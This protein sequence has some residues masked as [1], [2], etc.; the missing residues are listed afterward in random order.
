MTC[1]KKTQV[2]LHRALPRLPGSRW[3]DQGNTSHEAAIIHIQQSWANLL[4]EN[5]SL[6]RYA[7]KKD[8][9]LPIE[10]VFLTKI[11]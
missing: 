9:P 3:R 5:A 10:A 11:K 4:H 7:I 6:K 2:I 8:L 1:I